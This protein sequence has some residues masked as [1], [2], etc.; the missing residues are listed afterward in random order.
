MGNVTVSCLTKPGVND[1]NMA[2]LFWAWDVFD[3]TYL[4][5]KMSGGAVL[6]L[7][8][9]E[10]KYLPL[11]KLARQH[12]ITSANQVVG[13]KTEEDAEKSSEYRK[14]AIEA[15]KAGVTSKKKIAR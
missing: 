14:I 15:L 1:P 10:E 3:G 2:A 11:T 6:R 13:P 9:E 5:A 12:G 7:Y 4:E 8:E